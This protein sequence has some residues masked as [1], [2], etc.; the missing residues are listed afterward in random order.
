MNGVSWIN[1]SKGTNVGATVAAINGL[2]GR[3]V[4]IAGGVGKGADFSALRSSIQE[5]ISHLVLFGQDAN[6]IARAV[7]GVVPTHFAKTLKDAVA[8]AATFSNDGA[9]VLF[10]PA[11][12]SFDMFDSFEHRGDQFRSLVLEVGGE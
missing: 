4:L 10:S 7:D 9:F 6:D 11:C 3:G 1:D 12:S 2:A 5:K 8:Q